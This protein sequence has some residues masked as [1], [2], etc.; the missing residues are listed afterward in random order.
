MRITK[1]TVEESMIAQLT[2]KGAD[3][4][5]F[6][7]LVKDYMKLWATKEMLALDI[8]M[9]GVVYKDVS[10]VGVEMVKNNTSVKELIGV[11][12]QMLSILERLNITTDFAPATEADDDGL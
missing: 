5:V 2:A 1:K 7:D 8:E 10:S 6:I 9:R 12:R 4:P 11:N 3:T